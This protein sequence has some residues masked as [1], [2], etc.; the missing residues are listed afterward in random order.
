MI[1][2][3]TLFAALVTLSACGGQ[4]TREQP[5]DTATVS[6]KDTLSA[7]VKAIDTIRL[8]GVLYDITPATQAEFDALT[9]WE[10]DT[11]EQHNL[12]KAAGAVTR[13]G[14]TL[15]F[16]SA[17]GI[18]K[19]ISDKNEEGDDYAVY[20]YQ[21]EIPGTGQWL[22]LGMF[23][24]SFAYLMISKATGDTTYT[25]GLPVL[26]PDKKYLVCS[27]ADLEAAFTPNGFGIYKNGKVPA[28]VDE[29]L[30]DNWGPEAVKW[31]DAIHLLVKKQVIVRDDV[32]VENEG[33]QYIR[34]SARK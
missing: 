4:A 8:G 1:K 3:T 10:P 17:A 9:A 12:D 32:K 13:V 24:E 27:N 11:S 26:S 15:F 31:Q 19:L 14:D 6:S 25:I 22:S 16:H 30:V 28:L 7:I 5:G 18:T 29:T 21:G 23:Y 33:I 34:L 20:S 2:Y